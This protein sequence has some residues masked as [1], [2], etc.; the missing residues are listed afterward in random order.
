MTTAGRMLGE[1][2]RSVGKKPATLLYPAERPQITDK[3]R[4]RFRF[5]P[6]K[7]IGCKMCMRDCPSAAI[8]ITKVGEKKFECLL[9]LDKCVYCGQCVEVCPKDALEPTT[10]FELAQ[11]SRSSL[12]LVFHAKPDVA[13]ETK[14]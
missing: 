13:P 1:V 6:E 4:G 2:L 14:A 3:F 11:L 7:C 12:K 9:E 8:T 5:L 10:D